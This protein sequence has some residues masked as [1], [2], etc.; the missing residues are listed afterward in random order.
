MRGR[1]RVVVVNA[2]FRMVPW[3][4]VCYGADFRF[5][6]VYMREIVRSFR[7][8]L[9][10][11]S[12]QARDMFGLYWVKCRNESGLCKDPRTINGGGNSGYQAIH[13]A[14]MFGARRIVLLGYD[15]QRTWGQ[16]HWH[17]KHDGN[18]PNGKGFPS[19]IKNFAN[20]ARDLKRSGV[21][22][23]NATRETALRC[24]PRVTIREA[25]DEIAPA[26]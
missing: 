15:M 11:C 18:L 20:L 17:G 21:D 7:G 23:V 12:E 9:W 4:D 24:F 22:V 19:W 16:L 14:A 10:T 13:L 26:P 3:A 6:D 25:F 1:A 8:E 5:W 2:T